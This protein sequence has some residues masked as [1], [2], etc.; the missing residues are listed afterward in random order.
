MTTSPVKVG[1][2]LA[3]KYRV[4]CVLGVGGMGVVVAA[5]HIQLD[6]KV[7]IKFMLPEALSNREAVA[8]F[9]R[10]ARAA[11][12]IKS[13]HVA[14][15]SDVGTLES[16]APYMVMEYLEGSDLSAWLEQQGTLPVGQIVE[17]ILQACE[18]LAEAHA[19][20][21]VHRDLKPANLFVIRRPDGLLSVK[22]LDFGI[23]KVAEFNSAGPVASMTTTS[24][25]LGSPLYMSPEQMRSSKDVD[26]RSDIW[27]LG[28]ILY[29]LLAGD[30]PFAAD[31]M[32]E[33]VV[34]VMSAAPPPLRNKRPDAPDGIEA[35]ILKCLEKDRDRRFQ[36][37][38]ELAIALVA[39]GTSRSKASVERI[40]GV[41][42][43]ARYSSVPPPSPPIRPSSSSTTKTLEEATGASWGKTS[44]LA[45]PSRRALLAVGGIL[46]TVVLGS[47]AVSHRPST[48]PDVRSAS[49]YS[50]AAMKPSVAWTAPAAS[51]AQTAAAE[52]V[53]L[54]EPQVA[55]APS[56]SAS[57]ASGQIQ[58]PQSTRR[59]GTPNTRS[60][61]T[62]SAKTVDVIPTT[63]AVVGHRNPLD[64]R[65][66]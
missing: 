47:V 53:R 16:G 56:V 43:S 10:E 28:V 35:V 61:K 42:R 26:A 1:D 63:S 52:S 44:S 17:F 3:G 23:S 18:A 41:I 51:P 65:P 39:F 24:A 54:A 15:V 58:A 59:R 5:H 33:L 32:P 38:G 7:A 46:A 19:Y 48:A 29:E 25:L 37:V 20:G 60:A 27:S 50:A 36:T 30:S 12:K 13:E 14:R 34:R 31:T 4:D 9:A 55:P 49:S 2:V 45:R 6:D 66:Q 8:R 62:E 22:V 21:I 64:I 57:S 40:S 11:V